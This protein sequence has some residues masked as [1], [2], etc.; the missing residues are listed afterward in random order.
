MTFTLCYLSK[1]QHQWNKRV[2]QP[3]RYQ[4]FLLHRHYLYGLFHR[5]S[6][7]ILIIRMDAIGDAIL[8]LNQA[9]EYRSHYP[10]HRLVLL[11]NSTWSDLASRL[12]YFDLCI[13]ADR[14]RMD[15]SRSYC[16]SLLRQVNRYRYEKVICPVFSRDLPHMDWF[17]HNTYA[18]EKIAPIGDNNNYTSSKEKEQADRWYDHLIISGHLHIMELQRNTDFTNDLFKENILSRLPSIPFSLNRPK[19]IPYP[20]YTVFSL[21]ASILCKT[22]PADRYAT[23]AE[24]IS[25]PIVLCG[26]PAEQQLSEEFIQ[27]YHGTCSILNLTGQTTIYE[28][29]CL[30]AHAD[31]VV[32][33]DTATSHIAVATRTPSICLVGG[34][35]YGRFHPYQ[36]DI[37]DT[38]DHAIMPITVTCADH[39]CF[40]CHERCPYPLQNHRWRCIDN[41][42][43]QSVIQ[44]FNEIAWD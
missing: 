28:L 22:W 14:K 26:G 32:G 40:G 21:G 44:A 3:L 5:N 12:P 31:L 42:S 27:H 43:I 29:L 17:V 15:T 2:S 39:S 4:T 11:H 18:K 38:A 20:H 35:N 10:N 36:A 19:S 8:W 25:T 6:R 16:R 1:F 41:I 34:G 23:V 30:I 7:T 9:K 24:H 13:P 37:L 33:N